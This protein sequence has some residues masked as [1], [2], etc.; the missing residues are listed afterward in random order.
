MQGNTPK[1]LLI[2]G[3]GPSLSAFGV[4]DPLSDP[5]IELHDSTG[6]LISTNDNWR[7]DFN[8]NAIP[9]QLQPANES[10]SALDRVLSPGAY[11]VIMKGAHG[12]TGTGL[13]ELYDLSATGSILANISTRGIVETADNVMI[14]GFILR[15]AAATHQSIIVRALGPSLARFGITNTLS[16]PHLRVF[17]ANGVQLAD[18]DNWQ[19]SQAA[20][21]T[22]TGLAPGNILESATIL[23]VPPGSYTAIVFGTGGAT[24]NA[25]VE[26]YL[27]AGA[28]TSEVAAEENRPSLEPT[29][30]SPAAKSS[31]RP[32]P[33]P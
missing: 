8:H 3:L 24:G 5:L 12:Q 25:Q 4:A 33:L 28:S 26:V 7:S 20:A 27:L 18:N 23:S 14:A 22:Q 29:M 1:E 2:R 11:T 6:A 32:L 21:I 13:F 30:P 19:D 9:A 16:N 10:E 15:G 17:D 31:P